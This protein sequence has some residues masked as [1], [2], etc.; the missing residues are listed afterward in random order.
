ML[1]MLTSDM[2]VPTYAW[3]FMAFVCILTFVLLLR[4]DRKIDRLKADNATLETMVS[5]YDEENEVLAGN[6]ADMFLS[7]IDHIGKNF[8]LSKQ[9]KVANAKLAGTVPTEADDTVVTRLSYCSDCCG[10][11]W[12]EHFAANPDHV[13]R[14][15]DTSKPDDN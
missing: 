15:L 5:G 4:A 7:L 14:R 2:L 6:N 13:V 9:L 12:P 8:D 10:L 3:F 1:T 11:R